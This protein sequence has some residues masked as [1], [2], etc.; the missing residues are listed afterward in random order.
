MGGRPLT[1]SAGL[2]RTIVVHDI[3]GRSWGR[4]KR[5]ADGLVS[6]RAL[7]AHQLLEK[8]R[9]GA[10]PSVHAGIGLDQDIVLDDIET[11]RPIFEPG[12]A[13]GIALRRIPLFPLLQERA[14]DPDQFRVPVVPRLQPVGFLADLLPAIRIEVPV[15]NSRKLRRS[16][17]VVLALTTPLQAGSS[18][19]VTRHDD[20]RLLVGHDRRRYRGR[21]G[22]CD[23]TPPYDHAS[24]K[25]T[26]I[27]D[28]RHTREYMPSAKSSAGLQ[29]AAGGPGLA[30]TPRG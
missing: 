16:P 30:W 7:N 2:M 23:E 14:Q 11:R 17:P 3:A 10:L 24:P 19:G 4:P 6:P 13:L 21:R 25:R 9:D 1:G 12:V 26:V 18:A 29:E 15:V 27:A 28:C 5:S 22:S 8:R 20:E